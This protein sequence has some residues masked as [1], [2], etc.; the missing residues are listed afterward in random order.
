MPLKRPFLIWRSLASRVFIAPRGLVARG[1]AVKHSYVPFILAPLFIKM[2]PTFHRP[3]A[4]GFRREATARTNS[5]HSGGGRD[6][7][8]PI[9]LNKHTLSQLSEVESTFGDGIEY[10]RHMYGSSA[11]LSSPA[12]IRSREQNGRLKAAAQAATFLRRHFVL[13]QFRFPH[14]LLRI[15]MDLISLF[16]VLFSCIYLPFCV[17]FDEKGP[18]FIS[19]LDSMVCLVFFSFEILVSFMSWRTIEEDN[20]NLERFRTSSSFP[21]FAKSDIRLALLASSEPKLEGLK[22]QLSGIR[23]GAFTSIVTMSDSYNMMSYLRGYFIIDLLSVLPLDDIAMACT[24]TSGS[25]LSTVRLIRVI[26]LLRIIKMARLLKFSSRLKNVFG[27]FVGGTRRLAMLLMFLV[28]VLHLCSC[29]FFFLASE[30]PKGEIN[31]LDTVGDWPAGDTAPVPA[32]SK[33]LVRASNPRVRM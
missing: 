17:S 6:S 5:D 8:A 31:W 14:S 11:S 29:L 16:L 22:L 30:G 26:R 1:A 27:D 12:T 32:Y 13:W 10:F 25:S 3:A 9:E 4:K 21:M 28:F 2:P 20:P 19:L 33:Y 7:T 18:L 23:S 24:N 15:S